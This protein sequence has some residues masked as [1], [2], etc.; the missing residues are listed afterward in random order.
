MLKDLQKYIKDKPELLIFGYKQV[1]KKA[2]LGKLK[3]VFISND[4]SKEII[5]RIE[6]YSR[7]S[8]FKIYLLPKNKDEVTLLCKKNFPVSITTEELFLRLNEFSCFYYWCFK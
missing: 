4:C 1:S 6:D 5:D 8:D 7:F 2:K 3:E